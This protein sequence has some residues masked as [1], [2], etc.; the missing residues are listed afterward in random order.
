MFEGLAS[1]V[2]VQ[3][4]TSCKVLAEASF[5]PPSFASGAPPAASHGIEFENTQAARMSLIQP[6][7]VTRDLAVR[8]EDVVTAFSDLVLPMQPMQRGSTGKVMQIK[9]KDQAHSGSIER[10]CRLQ[11]PTL[12]TARCRGIL[13]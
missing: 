1:Q 4:T 6:A 13:R 7:N 2:Q 12:H 5:P 9:K 8:P 3:A 10:H 11:N